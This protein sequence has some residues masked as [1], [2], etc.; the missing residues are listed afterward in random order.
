MK[1]MVNFLLY[2]MVILGTTTS[3]YA[4]GLFG[5]D[6]SVSCDKTLEQV[7]AVT[8]IM[9]NDKSYQKSFTA[10]D[11]MGNYH[12]V[13][14]YDDNYMKI[15]NVYYAYKFRNLMHYGL[16]LNVMGDI[17]SVNGVEKVWGLQG[18][19]TAVNNP[20]IPEQEDEFIPQEDVKNIQI[21]YGII[22]MFLWGRL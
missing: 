19:A 13:I 20:V 2:I 14:I 22:L 15:D 16:T 3:V 12:K 8:D 18:Y 4:K 6:Y 11:K 5:T 1:K 7:K 17:K 10:K 9:E 21:Y